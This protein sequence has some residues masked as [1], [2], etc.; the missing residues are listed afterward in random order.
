MLNNKKPKSPLDKLKATKTLT[1]RSQIAPSRARASYIYGSKER[2]KPWL[3]ADGT[4]DWSKVPW[5]ESI[6]RGVTNLP[7]GIHRAF[8][9]TFTAFKDWDV[10]AEALGTMA[11]QGLW[12]PFSYLKPEHL[13]YNFL[14]MASPG[15]LPNVP[16]SKLEEAN[17]R[18]TQVFDLLVDVYRQN[19]SLAD[20]GAAIKQYIAEEP[21]AFLEDAAMVAT[22]FLGGSGALAKSMSKGVSLTSKQR[23]SLN[24]ARFARA[25]TGRNFGKTTRFIQNTFNV[26]G[27][28]AKYYGDRAWFIGT[29][30]A[31]AGYEP[32]YWANLAHTTLNYMDPLSAPLLAAGDALNLTICG[33]QRGIE[34]GNRASRVTNDFAEW[35]YENYEG[36]DLNSVEDL[37]DFM[38]TTHTEYQ[39][40]LRVNQADQFLDEMMG[41]QYDFPQSDDIIRAKAPDAIAEGAEELTAG[42]EWEFL[43]PHGAVGELSGNLARSMEWLLPDN[44]LTQAIEDIITHHIDFDNDWER[45]GIIDE[46]YDEGVGYVLAEYPSIEGYISSHPNIYQELVS[47]HAGDVAPQSKT[48]DDLSE[49][50]PINVGTDPTIESGPHPETGV[51]V[52]GV[53][54]EVNM[55]YS[56]GL[57]GEEALKLFR[58]FSD[59]LAAIGA[60]VNEST[61]LHVHIGK[62]HLT[63]DQMA[64]I[65][66]AWAKY[67]W[68]VDEL[69]GAWR[70]ENRGYHGTPSIYS[71]GLKKSDW[72]SGNDRL[73][74]AIWYTNTYPNEQ[75]AIAGLQNFLPRPMYV[76]GV[77]HFMNPEITLDNKPGKRLQATSS[78]Q[79]HNMVAYDRADFAYHLDQFG[80][81]DEYFIT[82]WTMPSQQGIPHARTIASGMQLDE[83]KNYMESLL[84]MTEP[85]SHKKHVVRSKIAAGV[86]AHKI[87]EIKK[88]FGMPKS[89]PPIDAR[90]YIHKAIDIYFD[91]SMDMDQKMRL[92]ERMSNNG[93]YIFLT[94]RPFE[95]HT[96]EWVEMLVDEDLSSYSES[97]LLGLSGVSQYRRCYASHP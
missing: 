52:E 91:E 73:D 75:D 68:A 31:E 69:Y 47:E 95:G 5:G 54:F 14:R 8:D 24:F 26:L 13:A 81:A 38:R 25:K 28:G 49:R 78:E 92:I 87:N 32:G 42:V 30:A 85:A 77:H 37:N 65:V 10:T 86:S 4:T 58:E 23:A 74:R 61:G 53:P 11:G 88:M 62:G 64:N 83:A 1:E 43:L 35:L 12:K 80:N 57:T 9:E 15:A 72:S 22:M 94:G 18:N 67:E 21:A 51:M 17:K 19:Y 63:S 41:A 33:I 76:E 45:S 16:K 29:G 48:L 7:E 89:I 79:A 6:A 82:E 3:R 90:T 59:E 96:A 40:E 60:G 55:P 44:V 36:W 84:S 2:K 27:D 71:K 93:G 70:R 34:S 46:L 56:G 66:R 20:N 50:Y 97:D 39:R